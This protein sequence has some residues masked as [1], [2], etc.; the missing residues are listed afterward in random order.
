M[1]DWNAFSFGF[2][3]LP[4]STRFFAVGP[5]NSKLER[6]VSAT[7]REGD[8]RM[9]RK[10][11][12]EYVCKPSQPMHF[13]QMTHHPFNPVTGR[14]LPFP[15]SM[16]PKHAVEHIVS[17]CRCGTTSVETHDMMP[18][19][20]LSQGSAPGVSLIDAIGP[21]QQCPYPL[22]DTFLKPM[23]FELL[24]TAHMMA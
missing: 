18:H 21:C 23:S 24:S 14:F 3:F 11:R 15:L 2:E 19:V 16:Y 8:E 10:R 7:P 5:R 20:Q 4:L 6:Q 22:P 17:A 9:G 1:K 13:S 12:D